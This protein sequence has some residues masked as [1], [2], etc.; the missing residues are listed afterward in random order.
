[1]DIQRFS[2][3]GRSVLSTDLTLQDVLAQVYDT[4]ERPRCMCVPGGVPMYVAKHR[5][6]VVKRMPDTGSKHHPSCQAYEPE[7]GT[8]GL[9][10][11]MGETVIEHT[12]EQ[13]EV[14]VD[15]P[16]SRVPGKGSKAA[17]A[18]DPVEPS[19]IHAPRRRM[20]LRALLH[21]L[22]ERAGFNRWYPLMVGKR[23]QGV[24]HKYILEAAQ[25]IVVKGAPL[26]ERLYVPEPFRPEQKQQIADRRRQKLSILYSPEDDAQFK[27]AL[28]IGQYNGVE[29]TSFG[30]KIA[31][32]HMPDA[33]LFIDAKAW[34][35]VERAYGWMLSA[36]DADTDSKPRI[37]LA[38][39]IYAKQPYL[40]QVDTLSMMLASEQWL[41]MDGLHELDLIERLCNERRSFIKPLQYDAKAPWIFPNAMLVDV[42]PTPQRL[43][44]I[45]GL[46]DPKERAA[47][48]KTVQAEGE[49]A[50]V[51]HVER[52]MPALPPRLASNA[53][54]GGMAR[55]N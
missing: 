48:E 31:V 40:Y 6:Y 13:L 53:Q 43:H 1:M 26:A 27:M 12:P 42:G 37:I 32:R 11:L 28:V 8:S 18:G 54:T 5:Q 16:F 17:A 19:E 36:L 4:P 46:S 15:F 41:P 50:W 20:S 49:S 24:F 35:R 33:P 21:L 7:T 34:D 55:V 10:E 23:N 25:E 47:K 30:R 14:R 45:N 39:L 52:E 51:W 44:V 29:S 3:K 2:I 22:Y 38:A 9:S